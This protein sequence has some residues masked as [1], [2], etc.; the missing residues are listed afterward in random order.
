GERKIN[1]EAASDSGLEQ[2]DL[3]E[4]SFCAF[5]M[6]DW[7]AGFIRQYAPRV[8]GKLRVIPL[9]RFDPDDAPTAS[10]GGS[11][12]GIP[13]GCPH[14]D[15]AWHLIEFLYLSPQS[16]ANRSKLGILPPLPELW[17][18]PAYHQDDPF[19]G[20]QK[21]LEIYAQLAPQVPPAPTTP[22]TG[23]ALAT[24]SYVQ[25]TAVRYVEK[26]GPAGLEQQCQAWLDMAAVDLKARIEH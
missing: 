4:G 23:L 3:E 21:L 15:D 7:K 17:D 24:L 1:A 10:Y 13:R 12:M 20:G 6:P 11:L 25:S 14:P 26:K 5:L 18:D 22:I 8:A 9:P 16:L 19:F 2:N